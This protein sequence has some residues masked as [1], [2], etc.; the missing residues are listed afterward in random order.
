MTPTKENNSVFNKKTYEM[1]GKERLIIAKEATLIDKDPIT[2][3]KGVY[4]DRKMP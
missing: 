4:S 2:I 3:N 1:M